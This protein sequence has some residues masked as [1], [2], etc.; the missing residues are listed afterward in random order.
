MAVECNGTPVSCDLTIY[1]TRANFNYPHFLPMQPI[2]LFYC[3]GWWL[4]NNHWSRSAWRMGLLFRTLR[5]S[6]RSDHLSVGVPP[7]RTDYSV[8]QQCCQPKLTSVAF[9]SASSSFSWASFRAS[10]YLSNSSSVA[11]SFFCSATRSSSSCDTEKQEESYQ[12][13]EVQHHH[14]S[15]TQSQHQSCNRS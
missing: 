11:F 13:V 8:R 6:P 12:H 5:G 10:E 1:S 14:H 9:F 7:T 15:R 4:Y 3:D 2:G